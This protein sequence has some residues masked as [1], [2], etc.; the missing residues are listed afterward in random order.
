LNARDNNGEILHQVLISTYTGNVQLIEGAQLKW[1]RDE[2]LTTAVVSEF[3]ELPPPK[4]VVGDHDDES[5][6]GRLIR[7][8]GDLQASRILLGRTCFLISCLT[9]EIT[10]IHHPLH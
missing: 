7:H 3:V 1:N 8:I 5:F 9:A 6:V 10:R 4:A 2:A